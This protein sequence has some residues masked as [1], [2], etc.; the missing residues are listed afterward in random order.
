MLS[1]YIMGAFFV[2]CQACILFLYK[3]QAVKSL[4]KLSSTV[5]VWHGYNK[6]TRDM[7]HWKMV[8]LKHT[9]SR[10]RYTSTEGHLYV[11]FAQGDLVNLERK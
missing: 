2:R 5:R 3:Y 6:L 11:S 10:P 1:S 7:T 9:P 4:L 8:D